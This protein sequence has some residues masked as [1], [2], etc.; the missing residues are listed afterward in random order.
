MSGAEAPVIASLLAS[1]EAIR[2]KAVAFIY[3]LILSGARPSELAQA[4]PE[5]IEPREVGGV[6][7]LP[8]SKTGERTIHLPP[9]VMAL[10]S[11]LPPGQG[12]L[13]GIQSPRALWDWVRKESGFTD[14]RMYDLRHTF[15]S[16]ALKAGYTLAQIGELLGHSSTQTTSRYA[17]L[18]DDMAQEVAAGTASLLEKTMRPISATSDTPPVDP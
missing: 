1:Q 18:L 11:K 14:L 3:L 5:W 17:H 7:K 10:I 2:P 15:A 12:T 6:L 4:R 13:L 16:Y 8:D 9:Q